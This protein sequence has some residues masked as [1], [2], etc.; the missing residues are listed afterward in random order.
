VW[1]LFV[2][3]AE[4]DEVLVKV[5]REEEIYLKAIVEGHL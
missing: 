4:M 5:R 3:I 1:E 2:R